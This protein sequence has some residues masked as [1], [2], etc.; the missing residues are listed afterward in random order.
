[1]KLIPLTLICCAAAPYLA[2]I[3]PVASASDSRSNP[4]TTGQWVP[5]DSEIASMTKTEWRILQSAMEQYAIEN[6]KTGINAVNFDNVKVYLRSDSRLYRSNG[7]D[8][9]GNAYGFSTIAAGVSVSPDTIH[10]LRTVSQEF[11][12][13]P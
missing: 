1:M 4:F 5:S 12:A 10:E 3:S 13:A 8:I 2:V 11:W 9:L 7:K 6:K